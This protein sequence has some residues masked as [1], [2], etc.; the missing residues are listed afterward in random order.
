MRPWPT[1]HSTSGAGQTHTLVDSTFS[2]GPQMIPAQMGLPGLSD[3]LKGARMG[4]RIVAVLPPKYGYGPSGQSE[5][6]FPVPTP[7]CG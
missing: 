7:W 3:A 2:S 4:S 6:R 1:S 5:L